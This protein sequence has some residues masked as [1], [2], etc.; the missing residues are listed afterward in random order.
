MRRLLTVASALLAL[1]ACAAK[2]E[3]YY[4]L[5]PVALQEAIKNC[6]QKQP[7]QVS[8]TQLEQIAIDV[9]QLAYQ[10]KMNPQGFGTKILTLQN[11]LVK[12]QQE[13]QKNPSQPALVTSIDNKQW[14]LAQHLAIVKWLE[15][16]ES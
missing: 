3:R 15:S 13:L 10:L 7:E 6:P 8:C 5:N 4:H 1:N 16:P 9:N 14:E 2:D 11:E 12:Q